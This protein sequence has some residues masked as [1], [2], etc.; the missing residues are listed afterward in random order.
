MRRVFIAVVVRALEVAVGR[1]RQSI[2]SYLW[3]DGIPQKVEPT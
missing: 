1:R 3:C 2:L